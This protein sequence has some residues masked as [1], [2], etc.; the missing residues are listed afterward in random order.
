[1]RVKNKQPVKD[2]PM[3]YDVPILINKRIP[4]G[5]NDQMIV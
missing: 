4:T 1:M 2:S 3:N 5:P